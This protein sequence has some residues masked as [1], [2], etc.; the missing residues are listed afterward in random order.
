MSVIHLSA[1]EM[2]TVND[3]VLKYF[4]ITLRQTEDKKN[5]KADEAEEEDFAIILPFDFRELQEIYS[6]E[7]DACSNDDFILKTLAV[8]SEFV[9]T[10][11][12]LLSTESFNEIIGKS[13]RQ[14]LLRMYIFREEYLE[15]SDRSFTLR[16]PRGSMLITNRCDWIWDE[17]I[18]EYFRRVLPDVESID[19]AKVELITGQKK[20]PG[21]KPKDGRVPALLWGT[22][23]L[24]HD[25]HSF[26]SPMPNCLCNFIVLLLQLQGVFRP[27]TEIDAMW[28]RAELR[29]IQ[30]RP[31][32]PTY[33]PSF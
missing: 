7:I 30:S 17:L 20:R 26:R 8:V 23:Q 9:I 21:R 6:S 31:Q 32:K 19:T 16:G 25:M 28:V 3:A 24:L 15:G 5:A 12:R 1:E 33:S 10:E 29:Y 14:D 22:Y 2:A 27:D 4:G 11:S 13:I 18:G